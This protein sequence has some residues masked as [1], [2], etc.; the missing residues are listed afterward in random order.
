MRYT[1]VGM[2]WLRSH[3]NTYAPCRVVLPPPETEKSR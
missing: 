1:A 2:S 3:G